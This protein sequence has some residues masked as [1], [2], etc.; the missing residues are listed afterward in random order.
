M[1]N[2]SLQARAIHFAG[3]T[4][5]HKA[6][7]GCGAWLRIRGA[8][9]EEGTASTGSA[10]QINAEQAGHASHRGP[11]SPQWRWRVVGV[12][13]LLPRVK[14]LPGRSR[15]LQRAKVSL[16][17]RQR[18]C[19]CC[20]RRN[21]CVLER[22]L[23]V[24]KPDDTHTPR[25]LPPRRI[26]PL[27]LMRSQY[28]THAHGTRTDDTDRGTHSHTTTTTTATQQPISTWRASSPSG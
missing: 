26:H 21:G 9:E 8:S 1:T 6:L 12:P 10:A 19:M 11:D 24:Q 13:S 7:T 15:G 5:T 16:Q 27:S 25:G 2:G 14:S 4:F 22:V 20:N 3:E 18:E 28:H 17:H 23:K